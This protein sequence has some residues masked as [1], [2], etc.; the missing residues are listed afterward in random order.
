[1]YVESVAYLDRSLMLGLSFIL[2]LV[3]FYLE[4]AKPYWPVF[5]LILALEYFELSTLQTLVMLITG[6]LLNSIKLY[7]IPIPGKGELNSGY[8]ISK[9]DNVELGIFYPTK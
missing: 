6:F 7:E 3:S 4:G 9:F 5:L 2:F 8:K 1:L